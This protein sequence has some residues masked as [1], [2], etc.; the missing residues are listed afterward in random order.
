MGEHAVECRLPKA[1]HL[2]EGDVNDLSF[3]ICVVDVIGVYSLVT[4][5][6]LELIHF[7]AKRL[8]C[9]EWVGSFDLVHQDSIGVDLSHVVGLLEVVPGDL[10]VRGNV[11]ATA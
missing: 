7:A 11:V 1:A 2:V 3:L 6:S 4:F 10:I 5:E 8:G 9:G